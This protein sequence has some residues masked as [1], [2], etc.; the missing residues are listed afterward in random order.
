MITDHSWHITYC[1]LPISMHFRNF[2]TSATQKH[3]CFTQKWWLPVQI[4]SQSLG[5]AYKKTRFL[6]DF[7][8][9]YLPAHPL[10]GFC[11]IWEIERWNSGRKRR[12]QGDFGGFEGFG[13]CLGITH[14]H[15]GEI[16]QKKSFFGRLPL[17]GAQ[18]GVSFAW[19][20]WARKSL[21]DVCLSCQVSDKKIAFINSAVSKTQIDTYY[22]YVTGC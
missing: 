21:T 16:S 17:E 19:K 9:M 12:F 2:N 20:V 15:L 11:E 4:N 3:S 8:Q 22:Y 5:K 13:P 6:G 14:P 1:T 7:F 18:V 10:Q